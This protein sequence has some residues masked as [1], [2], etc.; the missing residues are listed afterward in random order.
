MVI[1]T[2]GEMWEAFYALQDARSHIEYATVVARAEGKDTTP[3]NT[4]KNKLL[5]VI[6]DVRKMLKGAPDVTVC[7]GGNGIAM[8]VEKVMRDLNINFDTAKRLMSKSGDFKS[9]E[10][11]D[12]S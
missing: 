9:N 4:L 3:Y 1:K 8:H 2:Q 12:R 5:S 7:A 11:A 10:N 6:D